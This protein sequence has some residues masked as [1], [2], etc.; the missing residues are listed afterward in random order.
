MTNRA[1][2]LAV[3]ALVAGCTATPNWRHAEIP[4]ER[5]ARDEAACARWAAYE[6]D[7]EYGQ[8]LDIASDRGDLDVRGSRSYGAQMGLFE[9]K[10]RRATLTGECMRDRGYV[11]AK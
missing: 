4:K 6:V 11:P 7:R 3:A 8:D 10:R 1:F 9:T 2:L 5:W